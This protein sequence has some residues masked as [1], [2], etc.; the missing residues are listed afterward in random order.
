MR[1]ILVPEKHADGTWHCHGMI[2]GLDSSDIKTFRYLRYH[3][4]KVDS[5]LVKGGYSCWLSY[6]EKFGFCSLKSPESAIACSFYI[7]K[8]I[9]KDNSRLV[10]QLGS[11]LFYASHGLLKPDKLIEFYGRSPELDK[12]LKDKY[13]FCSTGF[14]MPR[15]EASWADFVS[16]AE[17]FN[18]CDFSCFEPLYDKDYESEVNKICDDSDNMSLWCA[19]YVKA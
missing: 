13:E 18:I 9:T 10:S 19:D 8:Y 4:W 15:H 17:S 3:G 5:K 14:V 7:T 6:H 2:S 11:H 12:L 16:L 1:Y